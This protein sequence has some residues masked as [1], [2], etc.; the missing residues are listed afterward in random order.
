MFLGK[1]YVPSVHCKGSSGHGRRQSIALALALFL[2][3]CSSA[4]NESNFGKLGYVEGFLGGVVADEPQ[5]A[6]IGRDMLSAGGSAVDAVVAMYFAAAVTLPSSASLGGGGV[7]L[8]FDSEKGEIRAL[9]FLARPPRRVVPGADRPTA[10]PG[11]VRGFYALHARYGRLT[12]S[13]VLGP[14]ESLARFGVRVSRAFARDLEQ[15]EDALMVEPETRRVFA[16]KDGTRLVREGDFLRQ[17]ELAAVLSLIRVELPGKFYG[18]PL[19]RKIAASA[20]EAGGS[21]DIEDLRDY[22]PVWR[23]T[24]TLPLGDEVVHF[25]PPPA[26]GGA[27]AAEMWAMLADDDRY[28]DASVEERHHL[29]AEAALRAYADRARWED[30]RGASAVDLQTLVSDPHI[31]D[32]MA[33]YRPD[34]HVAPE[35]LGLK[36][37][38]GPENPSAATFVAVDREG[39]AAACSV[40]LNSLFG[41]GRVASGTGIVLA[42]L[43][44]QG[45]RGARSL[46][47]MMI[48][49]EHVNNFYFVAA[50]SGG[51]VAPT[52][53]VDVA[54]RVLFGQQSLEEALAAKR[55]YGSGDP[56]VVFVERGLSPAASQALVRQ[57]HRIAETPSLGRVDAIYCPGGIPDQKETCAILA[58]PRGF[59]LAASAD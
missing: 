41:T 50:A 43:P 3:G 47:P 56:D 42:S 14:A 48:V 2:V 20:E 4:G 24:I 23:D 52:A 35:E 12:W 8:A 40:T 31:E 33:N 32:M 49:N 54:A 36:V 39:S 53:M 57:G 34:T 16:V 13:Q 44:G 59:G 26:T 28:E 37:V 6:L 9:D 11:N 7:C 17:P 15:V 19:A 51:V 21:L 46:G 30:G 10:V 25:A 27:V 58:D 29:V 55:V 45:G 38:A 22:K 1:V 5:A 18:G